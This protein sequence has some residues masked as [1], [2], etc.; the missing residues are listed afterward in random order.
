MRKRFAAES[1]AAG[2]TIMGLAI[3]RCQ[4]TGFL[5]AEGW[6]RN[7]CPR[8]ASRPWDRSEAAVDTTPVN[9]AIDPW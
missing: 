8:M 7:A 9:A 5:E 3:M 4:G 2:G 1:F 6:Q